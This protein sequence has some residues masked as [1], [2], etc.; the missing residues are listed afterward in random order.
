MLELD[1]LLMRFFD[2]NF[3]SMDAAQIN[4]FETLLSVQ[5]PLLAQW[6]FGRTEPED[7]LIGQLVQRIRQTGHR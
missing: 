5:D 6:L 4:S 3:D 1:I 7:R 2:R